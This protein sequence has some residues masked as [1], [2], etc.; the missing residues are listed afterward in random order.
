MGVCAATA[1]ATPSAEEMPAVGEIDRTDLLIDR[2]LGAVHLQCGDNAGCRVLEQEVGLVVAVEVLNSLKASYIPVRGVA[3]SDLY[4]CYHLGAVHQPDGNV[5]VVGVQ[6]QQIGLSIAVEATDAVELPSRIDDANQ[7]RRRDM[8]AIGQPHGD[9]MR[10]VVDE[11][12]IRF[13]VTV[14]IAGPKIGQ[15]PARR[16]V[17]V[18]EHIN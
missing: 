13:T 11:Q 15:T 8:A 17:D 16:C 2:D 4:A 14:K 12:Q 10:D 3:S 6:E 1:S 9:A 5:M 18:A 7:P